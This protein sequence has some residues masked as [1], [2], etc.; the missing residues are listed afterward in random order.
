MYQKNQYYSQLQTKSE[1]QHRN[2]LTGGNAASITSKLKTR[3]KLS[4]EKRGDYQKTPFVMPLHEKKPSKTN[5]T[6]AK[7]SKNLLANEKQTK[8]RHKVIEFRETIKSSQASSPPR[9]FLSP[10]LPTKH[11]RNKKEEG[12]DAQTTHE[13]HN[14]AGSEGASKDYLRK[15]AQ[16][17]EQIEIPMISRRSQNN[18]DGDQPDTMTAVFQS[19]KKQPQDFSAAASAIFQN[20][21]LSPK[22]ANIAQSLPA[23]ATKQVLNPRVVELDKHLVGIPAKR[24]QP[25]PNALLE[26]IA[27]SRIVYRD[28]FNGKNNKG[29]SRVSSNSNMLPTPLDPI[30]IIET[31]AVLQSI[32][33]LS[34]KQSVHSNH[35]SKISK[36]GKSS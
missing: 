30:L 36:A 35:N 29:M 12:N 14:S 27:L 17:K 13:T 5:L 19:N 4:K 28:S 26:K 16:I 1:F 6:S 21:L 22:I 32:N 2:K 20:K 10:R 33:A 24:K 15:Y 34:S 23:Q 25:N 7:L 31:P 3:Q 8:L 11:S 9:K 18:E